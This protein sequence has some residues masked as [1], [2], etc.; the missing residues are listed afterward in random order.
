M[1]HRLTSILLLACLFPFVTPIRFGFDSQPYALLVS[2]LLLVA[3]SIRRPI[4]IKH[5]MIGFIITIILALITLLINFIKYDKLDVFTAIRSTFTLIN[6]PLGLL[7]LFNAKPDPGRI[8]KYVKY[9]ILIYGGVAF[10]QL[11]YKSFLSFILARASTSA[12]R[13]SFSLAVEPVEYARMC[14]FFFIIISLFRFYDYCTAKE[15]KRLTIFLIVQ[16]LFFSLAGTA[17]IWVLAIVILF[18][19]YGSKLPAYKLT[20]IFGGFILLLVATVYIGITYFPDK[21][22]FYLMS[23]AIDNPKLLSS[24]AGFVLRSLNPV[25]SVIVGIYMFNGIGVG[26]GFP[27]LNDVVN[28]G[29]LGPVFETANLGLSGRSHGGVSSF[30]YEFGLLAVPYI[31]AIILFIR[32]NYKVTHNGI[33]MKFIIYSLLVVT[34]F[35]GPFSNSILIIVIG[36]FYYLFQARKIE[37]TVLHTS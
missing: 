27:G 20:L 35:D 3:I 9:A 37:N 12:S 8:Y 34:L 5:V 26:L 33:S 36:L 30:I 22:L 18:F 10:V 13:G 17:F 2:F 11:F 14:I 1:I 7:A 15:Y 4:M 28:Y 29:F 23:V 32:P 16:V 24:F 31:A 6:L 19:L 25:H 21:R